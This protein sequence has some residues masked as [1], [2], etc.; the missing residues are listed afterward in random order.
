VGFHHLALFLHLTGVTLW[1][2]GMAFIRFCLISPSLTTAQWATTLGKFFPLSWASI[3]LI[4]L[5]GGFMLIVTGT[6]Q[7]PRAWVWMS[8]LGAAMIAI[9][10]SLWFAPWKQLCAALKR[11]D[12]AQGKAA[13]LRINRRLDM[14]LALAVLTATAATLGLAV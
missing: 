11:G 4:V 8:F 9:Y 3:A 14:A 2:G 1:V 7:A 6:A 10:A 12:A 5:S 13:S